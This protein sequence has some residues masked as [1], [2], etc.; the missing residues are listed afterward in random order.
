MKIILFTVA[1]ISC[2]LGAYFS[3]PQDQTMG[4]LLS[5]LALI[6]LAVGF[7]PVG[8]AKNIACCSTALVEDLLNMGV[9]KPRI[10]CIVKGELNSDELSKNMKAY[11]FVLFDA[12]AVDGEM[13]LDEIFDASEAQRLGANVLVRFDESSYSRDTGLVNRTRQLRRMFEQNKLQCVSTPQLQAVISK[14]YGS[15]A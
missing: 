6:L 8:R 12:N 7:Y 10:A 11:A 1:G 13:N 4:A 14:Y 5:C 15:K 2:G 9:E 3:Y